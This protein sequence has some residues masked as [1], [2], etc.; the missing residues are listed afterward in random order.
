MSL[1]FGKCFKVAMIPIAIL[2]AI[3]IFQNVV[4]LIPFVN[5]ILCFIGPLLA[6]VSLA[7]LAWSGYKAVKEAG[8]DLVGGAVT[9]AVA[10]AVSSLVNAIIGFVLGLVGVGAGL[11]TGG[12]DTV[13]AAIGVG[14]GIVGIII[15]PIIG[16]MVGAVLGAIGAFVAGMK[17]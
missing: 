15:A 13:G 17:K 1:D 2:V 4:G 6:L 7:V 11:A 3:G 14:F 8:M 10:G 5:L 9:G 16:A 12:N